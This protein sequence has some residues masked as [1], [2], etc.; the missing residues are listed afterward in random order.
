MGEGIRREKAHRVAGGA[1]PK[2]APTAR[3]MK[4]ALQTLIVMFTVIQLDHCRAQANPVS[5]WQFRQPIALA[6]N[7]LDVAFG[8]GRFMAVSDNA[9]A[10]TSADGLQWSAV[11]SHQ[12]FLTL[13]CTILCHRASQNSL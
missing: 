12:A 10:V 8:D 1:K 9:V 6:G 7:Y 2:T 5:S 13:G 3:N 4:K 11:I